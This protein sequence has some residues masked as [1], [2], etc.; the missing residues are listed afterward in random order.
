MHEVRQIVFALRVLFAELFDV[1][2]EEV[3][4]EKVYAGIYLIDLSLEGAAVLFLDYPYDLPLGA[5]HYPAVAPGVL[6]DCS[7][8][9]DG[10][11]CLAFPVELKQGLYRLFPYE[12]YIS[13]EDE[14]IP[15]EIAELFQGA[16]DRMPR[17]ELLFLR[18]EREAVILEGLYDGFRAEAHDQDYLS[19]ARVFEEVYREKEHRLPGHDVE[20]LWF[21]RL[22]PCAL[23][24]RKDNRCEILHSIKD[25]LR[26]RFRQ[27]VWER[28]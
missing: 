10:R 19:S 9:G 25:I 6:L 23:A 24:C 7:D 12:R 28:K 8:N 2:V 22:H 17:A 14:Y 5:A 16:H 20:Y 1:G 4:G 26:G 13:G 18:D 3:R 21:F 11:L 27:G 15:R